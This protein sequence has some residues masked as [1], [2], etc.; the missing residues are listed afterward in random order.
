MIFFDI[1]PTNTNIN[2]HYDIVY[3]L[4]KFDWFKVDIKRIDRL[5]DNLIDVAESRKQKNN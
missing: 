5:Y 3:L 2:N 4:F 1:N